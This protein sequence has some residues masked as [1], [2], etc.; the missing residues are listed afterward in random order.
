[1]K[2][3]SRQIC[4]LRLTDDLA[5]GSRGYFYSCQTN[6]RLYFLSLFIK[7]HMNHT[8]HGMRCFLTFVIKGYYADF[9]NIF[10]HVCKI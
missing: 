8:Q 3:A 2:I 4:Y 9:G 6:Q 5:V 1:M 7:C 10:K